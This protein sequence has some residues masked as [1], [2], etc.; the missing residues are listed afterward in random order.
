MKLHES[1]SKVWIH[2]SHFKRSNASPDLNTH[3]FSWLILSPKKEQAGWFLRW[4]VFAVVRLCGQFIP[5]K[6]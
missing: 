1:Q 3:Y 6:S 2:T 4:L 5:E